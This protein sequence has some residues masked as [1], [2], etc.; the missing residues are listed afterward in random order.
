M[1]KITVDKASLEGLP[2][3]PPG[4]Y[5]VRFDGFKPKFP[6]NNKDSINLNPQMVVINNPDL[7]DRKVPENL[8]SQAGWVIRDMVH[9]FGLTMGGADG[10]E[11]PGE[12]QPPQEQDPAKWRYVGPLIGR[13][14]R[15]EVVDADNGKGGTT[16]KVKRYFCAVQGC[17]EK[18]SESLL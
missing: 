7:K 2:K 10:T 16:A 3:I 4:I 9:A 1:P 6:K 12:F 13:T 5:E 8:N 18:H 17:Q 11:L 15:V 14:G